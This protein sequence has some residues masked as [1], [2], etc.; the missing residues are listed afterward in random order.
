MV[1]AYR[2]GAPV[3]ISDIGRAIDGPENR[4]LAGWQNGNRGIILMVFKQPGANVIDTVERIKA[5]LPRL[6]ASIP[7]SIHVGIIMDPDG[8]DPRLGG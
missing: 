1:I 4:M 7:P 8:N 3:R 5:A 6:E 2:N